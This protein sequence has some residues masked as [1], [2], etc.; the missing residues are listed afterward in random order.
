MKGCSDVNCDAWATLVNDSGIDSTTI[1]WRNFSAFLQRQIDEVLG[2]TTHSGSNNGSINSTNST[3]PNPQQ[4][5]DIP[6]PIRHPV[7]PIPTLQRPHAEAKSSDTIRALSRD[8]LEFLR[9]HLVKLTSRDHQP[10][11]KDDQ[12]FITSISHDLPYT[13]LTHPSSRLVSVYPFSPSFPHTLCAAD[14]EHRPFC[15]FLRVV[16]VHTGFDQKPPALDDIVPHRGETR[17]PWLH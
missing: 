1:S 6:D 13:R 7:L 16:G 11:L 10:F 3:I 4:A 14:V 2:L 8:E 17:N 9:N 12:V 5:E 15:K